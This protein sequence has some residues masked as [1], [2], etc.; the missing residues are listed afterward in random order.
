ME[1]ELNKDVRIKRYQNHTI[2][3][4]NYNLYLIDVEFRKEAHFT[5]YI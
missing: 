4:E 3:D 5:K 2:K 1:V